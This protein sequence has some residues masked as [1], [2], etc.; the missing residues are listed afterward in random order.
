MADVAVVPSG[1]GFF[2]VTSDFQEHIVVWEP[3]YIHL[4]RALPGSLTH[5]GRRLF[6]TGSTNA[7]EGRS[8]LPL[9]GS[10]L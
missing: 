2:S 4:P 8:T 1:H 7:L 9:E 6:G 10:R 5:R 3:R